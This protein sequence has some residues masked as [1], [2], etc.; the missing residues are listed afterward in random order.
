LENSD[1]VKF[2]RSPDDTT[3]IDITGSLIENWDFV[4]YRTSDFAGYN[5]KITALAKSTP[6]FIN[7]IFPQENGLLLRL[8]LHTTS[9]IPDLVE[10]ISVGVLINDNP[11]WTGFSDI[12]GN[13]IGL[14]GD[15]YDPQIVAF[16]NGAI[17]FG[18]DIPG[19]ANGDG[20]INIGDPV[21][22]VNYV[23]RNGA[24]PASIISGDVNC[25]SG[26]D[27]GDAVYLIKYVFKSGPEP[28]TKK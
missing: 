11:Q 19:D 25:D 16:H 8:V 26:C 12:V 24:E 5:I 2:G 22:I 9:E 15:E 21:Y 27:V 7:G 4:S 1:L 23:F 6:P 14:A 18:G 28:C 13:L 3:A 20:R 17:I 10:N